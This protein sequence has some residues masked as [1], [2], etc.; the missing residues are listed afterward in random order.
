[1]L[2]KMK[3]LLISSLSTL[4]TQ[5]TAAGNSSIGLNV[6]TGN[7]CKMQSIIENRI[8]SKNLSLV[9]ANENS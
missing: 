9:V 5:S 6:V 7:L 3:R 4:R 2:T 8:E 1:M